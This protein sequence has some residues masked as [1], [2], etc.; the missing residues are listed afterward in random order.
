VIKSA[1]YFPNFEDRLKCGTFLVSNLPRSVVKSLQL[2]ED[3]SWVSPKEC[4]EA[5]MEKE[6]HSHGAIVDSSKKGDD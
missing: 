6:D 4:E 5:L 2:V 3:L 1:I